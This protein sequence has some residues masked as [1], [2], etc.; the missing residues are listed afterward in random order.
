LTSDRLSLEKVVRGTTKAAAINL[1]YMP[2]LDGLRFLAIAG[3]LVAHA[4]VPRPLPWIFGGVNWGELG[5]RLFFVLS[6]FLIT[7]ILLD[8]RERAEAGPSRRMFFL[9]QFYVRRFLRIFPLYYGVLLVLLVG[10]FERTR[11]LAS[12]L[13]TYTSNIVIARQGWQGQLGH[14]W[15]LAVEE[16][17]YLVWPWLL[18]FLPRRCLMP[19]LAVVISLAPLYRFYALHRYGLS[20]A[21]TDPRQTLTP[22]VLDSLGIGALVAIAARSVSETTF[23]ILLSRIALPM[24]LAVYVTL[25]ALQHYAVHP[26][27]LFV[28]G[29]TASAIAFG[30]LVWLAARGFRGVFGWLLQLW[31]VKYV[32]KISYGVYIFHNLVIGAAVLLAVHFRVNYHP[33]GILNFLAVSAVTI[34]IAALSWHFF[35]RPV[36][37]L[38]RHFA[39]RDL[40]RE[41]PLVP[42]VAPTTAGR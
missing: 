39:Y 2:Q 26:G 17:F 5:V 32:G 4:W 16:Q 14:F 27:A 25:L 29:D 23:R 21:L 34:A 30:W 20:G 8:C 18:L 22:A 24:S 12:W 7:G 13:F 3:V 36:N 1:G 35:E 33:D 28:L 15:T 6:G 10:D 31:P 40:R 37:G 38:K 19:L 9:R 11:E 41:Q 42:A